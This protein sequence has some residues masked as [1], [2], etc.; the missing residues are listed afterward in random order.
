M[1]HTPRPP[2]PVRPALA[3]ALVA[4][5]LS[6]LSSSGADTGVRIADAAHADGMTRLSW[7]GGHGPYLV[8]VSSDL[9]RWTDQGEPVPGTGADLTAA[10]GPRFYRVR[11]L[12]PDDQLGAP[13]GRI[14]TEQSE[15]HPLMARHRLKTRLWLYTSGQAP[16]TSPSH[17]AA[18]YWR[19][20]WIHLQQVDGGRVRTWTGRLE[21]LGTVATPSARRMTVSWTRGAGPERRDQV[22]TL[23]FPYDH[24]AVRTG[25]PFASD[26]TYTLTA[27]Y[28]SPQPEWEEPGPTLTGTLSD[29]VRLIQLAPPDPSMEFLTRRY[30]VRRNGARVNLHFREGMP[31]YEGSVPW[32][33]KTFPLER[34]L[35]PATGSGGGLPEFRIDGYFARTVMP[36]HHNF[37]HIVLL[38]PALDPGISPETLAA[39]EA[40][41]IR[42]VYTF[43]DQAGI[44]IGGDA[45]DIR[46]IGFDGSIRRP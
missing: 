16:H 14:E 15:F 20:L 10:G 29:T 11:D 1:R 22:L 4:S 34:W 40:A 25:K 23:D 30:Q 35:E 26:P 3:L 41:N 39:F 32:I 46:Y 18:A 37:Y 33:L 43:K 2:T 31:L 17:T 24:G 42:Q 8:E 5:V 6:A 44:T 19:A 36:G 28:A 12:D 13:F 7:Q 21:D 9:A 45:E 27:T 38:D